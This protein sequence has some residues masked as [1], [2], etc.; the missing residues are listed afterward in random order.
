MEVL[1][2]YFPEL[3]AMQISKYQELYHLYCYWNSKINI[4]S[5]KDIDNLYE[6]HILHSMA[7]IKF[8]TFPDNC[9]I[10]DV[11]TGGGF[12]GIPL[13]IFYPN[14]NFVLIDSVG[15]KIKVVNDIVKTLK[16]SNIIAL[17]QRVEKTN[18]YCN[19]AISRA[20]TEIPILLKWL[21]DKILPLNNILKPSIMVYKGGNFINELKKVPYVYDI[22]PIYTVLK[23][24]YYDN[25]Y[26]VH[27]TIE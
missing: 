2:K 21:K 7:C 19:I 18:E 26:L 4:V 24:S 1:L 25:K 6:R 22:Y 16:L 5:R 10:M 12:P 27:I 23:D 15:K 11:G 3:T 17:H 13:A 14:C 20:V 9:K 8:F